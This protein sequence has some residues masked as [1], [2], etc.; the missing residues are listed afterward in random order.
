MLLYS[1]SFVAA[2]QPGERGK[3]CGIM[4]REPPFLEKWRE[5]SW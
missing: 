2:G 3:T 4:K 5:K 1:A